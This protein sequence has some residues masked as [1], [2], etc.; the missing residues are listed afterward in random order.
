MNDKVFSLYLPGYDTPGNK[1]RTY[2]ECRNYLGEFEH[3]RIVLNITKFWREWNIVCFTSKGFINDDIE[4]RNRD[5]I[6]STRF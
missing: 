6:N 1:L 5:F 3:V 2:D 4:R